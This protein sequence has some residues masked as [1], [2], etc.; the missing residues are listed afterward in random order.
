MREQLHDDN[1]E[2]FLREKINEFDGEPNSQMWD[3]IEGVIPPA[4]KPVVFK[5]LT[6]VTAAAS[7]LLTCAVLAAVYQYRSN[8]DLNQQLIEATDKIK[9]LENQTE[10]TKTTE[11]KNTENTISLE[12]AESITENQSSTNSQNQRS[13]QQETSDKTNNR[14]NSTTKNQ[15]K[16]NNSSTSSDV[17]KDTPK[18]SNAIKNNTPSVTDTDN[19]QDK[20]KKTTPD[21]D[22]KN[23]APSPLQSNV[24]N[25]TSVANQSNDGQLP[26]SQKEQEEQEKDTEKIFDLKNPLASKAISE[27]KPKDTFWYLDSVKVEVPKFKDHLVLGAFIQPMRTR[28]VLRA[29]P[30]AGSGGGNQPFNQHKAKP[31]SSWSTGVTI[32]YQASKNWSVHAGVAYQTSQFDMEFDTRIR[33]DKTYD[34]PLSPNGLRIHRRP[35]LVISPFGN[36]DINVDLR[37]NP[38][39]QIPDDISMRVYSTG[40]HE[41]SNVSLPVYMQAQTVRGALKTGFKFGIAP[42]IVT[43]SV[44]KLETVAAELEGPLNVAFTSRESTLSDQPELHRQVVIDGLLGLIFAYQISLD[45]ELSLEP[46]LMANMG[47]KHDTQFGSTQ[48]VSTGL[49]IGYKYHF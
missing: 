7:V 11:D 2:D 46:T 49:Q 26:T 1:F 41:I 34:G 13:T 24:D 38:D 30:G 14:N 35:Y 15:S 44:F 40:K 32:G 22:I 23:D 29:T 33:Y 42:Q 48:L 10:K 36:M 45:A 12:E 18:Q 19:N 43:N 16:S 28:A 39:V 20:D 25:K 31:V 9:T 37:R 17:K 3:R 27:V 5:Y 47:R 4:P 6:P 8:R 21:A